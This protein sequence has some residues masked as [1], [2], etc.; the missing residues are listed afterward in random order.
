MTD[1]EQRLAEL[2]ARLNERDAYE[3]AVLTQVIAMPKGTDDERAARLHELADLIEKGDAKGA[4]RLMDDHV[5]MI[6]ARRVAEHRLTN[7]HGCC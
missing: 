7:Q 4:R 6:R 1:P 3:L 2:R 5:K